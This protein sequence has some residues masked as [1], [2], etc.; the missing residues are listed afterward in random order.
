M[1]KMYAHHVKAQ[2]K[3]KTIIVMKN[4]RVL[5]QEQKQN[6]RTHKENNADGALVRVR[7]TGERWKSAFASEEYYGETPP[8]ATIERRR[9]PASFLSRRDR[10]SPFVPHFPAS[11]SERSQPCFPARQ[12]AEASKRRLS[13]LAMRTCVSDGICPVNPMEQRGPQ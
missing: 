9:V 5:E 4:N 11:A 8:A 3:L 13:S 1:D 7:S 6:W 12:E 10:M 2:N